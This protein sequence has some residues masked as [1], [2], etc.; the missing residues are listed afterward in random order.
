MK[1]GKGVNELS[2]DHVISYSLSVLFLSPIFAIKQS[3][4]L[5]S[6]TQKEDLQFLACLLNIKAF[7]KNIY[8]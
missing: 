7:I 1:R 6:I 8:S 4:T 3:N 2:M 5:A